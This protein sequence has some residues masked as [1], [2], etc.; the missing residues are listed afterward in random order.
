MR[1]AV[2]GG[3][4]FIGPELVRRAIARG[5]SVVVLHRGVHA[6][7]NE[8][9]EAVVVERDDRAALRSALAA[10]RP[11][12][13][14]DT[15][16]M[17]E[18]HADTIVHAVGEETPLV[19]LSSQDVYAQFGRLLGHDAPT[20]EATVTESS[21]LTIPYPY[22]D[23][24]GAHPE[25]DYDKK[26]VERRMR[27]AVLNAELRSVTAL[28]LPP[29]YGPGD[30]RR[31][32][33][34]IVDAIDAGDGTLP[35]QGG[36]AFRWTH[37]HVLDV[38]EAIVMAAE[39]SRPGYCVYNVGETETPTMR[40]WAERF[41]KHMGR[42]LR[43][44]EESDELPEPLRHLGYMDTDVVV[45]TTLIRAE[46]GVTEITDVAQRV[47]DIVEWSRRSRHAH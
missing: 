30:D 10:A 27:R 12:A 21:P 24:E 45:D 38:G 29:T 42:Q 7:P 15:R 32:F 19:V 31:R 9:A 14:I 43:W 35:C 13:V 39:Q 20:S 28:R 17:T 2:I 44:V 25:L 34:G 3:T 23:I 16:S 26:D 36:A 18:T 41:A 6:N 37:A 1:L 47:R 11:D 5:H 22:R 8:D 33:G 46:R 40:Q 4:R